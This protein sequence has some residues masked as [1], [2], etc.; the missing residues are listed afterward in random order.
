MTTPRFAAVL[1]AAAIAA[2]GAARAQADGDI[3]ARVAAAIAEVDAARIEATVRTLVGFGT[4]HVLSR[5]DSDTEG[6]G[7]AR[8]RPG[9]PSEA[10]AP[11][12][13]GGPRR[14]VG[15][16]RNTRRSPPAPTGA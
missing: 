2:A 10:S 14:G 9:A 13:H 12:T 5:T 15:S 3:R 1:V 16:R 8:R 11:A 4:R 7:G 6:T